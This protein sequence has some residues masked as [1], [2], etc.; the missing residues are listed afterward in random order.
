MRNYLITFFIVLT[1]GIFF[2]EVFLPINPD[3]KEEVLFTIEKGQ[4]SRD[5]ALNLEKEGLIKWGPLFR[6]Y[7]LTVGVSGKLQAGD[8]FISSSM[9]IPEISEKLAL[10][11]IAKEKITIIEGWDLKD[12][13]FYF[14]NRGMFQAEEL[15][16]EMSELEGYLFPD[17]YW[18]KR[19]ASLKEITGIMQDN[20]EAKT[21]GLN[22]TPDVVIMAS[23]LER[24]LQIMKD[25]EIASGILWKRLRVGM[26][27]QVDAEM[28]TYDNRGLPPKPICNPGLESIEAAVYPE[29]SS[30]WYYL[31][32]PEGET[33]FSKTL[34]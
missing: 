17:T 23:L 19:G 14:E 25:K 12:I 24:E 11:D 31:S 34:E 22:I 13:G 7:V 8:Y 10:G 2:F 28:W 3:S 4:G 26:P 5:I 15:Y 30:Y 6:L 9:N 16:D 33:I 21:R 32:T 29:E 1:V 20:F 27:L 18:V